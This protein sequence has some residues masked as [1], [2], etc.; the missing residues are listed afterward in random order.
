[1]QELADKYS[2][3]TL[4]LD[5]TRAES[6]GAAVEEISRRAG[7]KLDVLVNNA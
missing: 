7:G 6:V 5:V 2:I 3:E 4:H 1:M